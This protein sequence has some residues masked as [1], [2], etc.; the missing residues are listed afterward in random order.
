MLQWLRRARARAPAR[1]RAHTHTHTHAYARTHTHTYT[2]ALSRHR[3]AAPGQQRAAEASRKER[4][5]AQGAGGRAG[6]GSALE[7]HPLAPANTLPSP[8][9]GANGF[10]LLQPR[11]LPGRCSE[12]SSLATWEGAGAGQEPS[13]LAGASQASHPGRTGGPSGP[14]I[15]P[16]CLHGWHPAGPW[17]AEPGRE[18]GPQRRVQEIK[19]ATGW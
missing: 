14:G 9:V 12:L 13:L 2:H 11:G 16:P 1:A 19:P 8:Q 3:A 18:A 7:Q 4:R 6:S 15:P 17:Q 10:C 5:A